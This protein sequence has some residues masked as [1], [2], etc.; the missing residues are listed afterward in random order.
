VFAIEAADQTT[1]FRYLRLRQLTHV[2]HTHFD[3]PWYS[4]ASP[5]RLPPRLPPLLSLSPSIYPKNKTF[6]TSWIYLKCPAHNRGEV[7]RPCA[8]VGHHY[9]YHGYHYLYHL[10]TYVL[11]WYVTCVCILVP[12]VCIVSDLYFGTCRSGHEDMYIQGFELYGKLSIKV[13]PYRPLPPPSHLP[14]SL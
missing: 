1:H 9:H 13:P 3:E 4:L 7:F 8:F 6:F 12:C 10:A 11:S 2:G 14:N 5:H